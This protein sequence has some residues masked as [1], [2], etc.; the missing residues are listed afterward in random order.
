MATQEDKFVNRLRGALGSV[1]EKE[2]DMFDY[3]KSLAPE[4]LQGA[5]G[6]ALNPA[7]KP[8]RDLAKALTSQTPLARNAQAATSAIGQ[9]AEQ[10]VQQ[11]FSIPQDVATRA[12]ALVEG[13][14]QGATTAARSFAGAGP[15][16]A[17]GAGRA[18]GQAMPQAPQLA[19][20]AAPVQGAQAA[21]AVAP[22]PSP[23]APAAQAQATAP[24][25]PDETDVQ[26]FEYAHD[27]NRKWGGF[28]PQSP[29]DQQKMAVIKQ[30]RSQDPKATP[31]QIA[32]RAYKLQ[33]G[34]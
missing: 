23:M 3:V 32:L 9:M 34:Q 12:N 5:I 19:P 11:N 8:R 20:K 1:L 22:A 6:L 18:L 25:Q 29:V 13:I 28:N 27:P 21:Q 7:T 30:L 24:A 2:A 17:A 14:T 33:Y 26:F 4:R 31:Q 15:N 10:A 16:I